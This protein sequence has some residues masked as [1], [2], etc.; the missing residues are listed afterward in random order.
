MDQPDAQAG[1]GAQQ[2]LVDHRG[3]VVQIDRGRDPAGGEPAHAVR[4]PGGRCPRVA[5]TDSRA[6]AAVVVDER[7]Q[8]R[9]AAVDR[10]AVQCVT[11]PPHVRG[12]GL[13]AAERPGRFPV[14]ASAE[15]QAHE[16]AL[17]G[18]FVRRPPGV[19]AQDRRDLRRGAGRHLFLQCRCQVEHV[20]RGAW[21]DPARA[22]HQRVEP[23]AAP[24][25]DPPVDSLPRYPHR[26]TKRAGMLAGRQLTHQ[27]APL[28]GGQSRLGCL[29]DQRIPEQRNR[30]GPFG[31]DLIFVSTCSAVAACHQFL[32]AFVAGHISRG[33]LIS[34]RRP[35]ASSC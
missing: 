31:P 13:E 11:S 32:L 35:R 2:L 17:Q 30:P 14:R 33:S 12:V 6:A 16:V 15:L 4:P 26:L 28:P 7:E 21:R 25:A 10:R 1:A 8:D 23:A 29:A 19:R 20:G 5:P 24:A 18:A 9:L 27:P 34:Q 22:G 3:T